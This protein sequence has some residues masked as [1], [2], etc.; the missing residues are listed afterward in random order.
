MNNMGYNYINNQ[1]CGAKVSGSCM[2]YNNKSSQSCCDSNCPIEVC[3]NKQYQK[4]IYKKSRDQIFIEFDWTDFLESCDDCEKAFITNSTWSEDPVQNTCDPSVTEPTLLKYQ[5]DLKNKFDAK[6]N[7]SRMSYEG[8]TDGVT[9]EVY[10]TIYYI[11]HCA[12]ISHTV[13]LLVTIKDC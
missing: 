9:Y 1:A 10:N 7:I 8:G 2:S 4:H 12:E 5:P 6:S 13:K 3:A 11:K